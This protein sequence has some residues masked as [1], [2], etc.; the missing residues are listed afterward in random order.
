MH[1]S[2]RRIV[3][4][5]LVS[6][7]DPDNAGYLNAIETAACLCTL[8]GS[9]RAHK[10]RQVFDLFDDDD[11]GWISVDELRSF[12]SSVFRMAFTIE[13][14]E[15]SKLDGTFEECVNATVI[16]CFQYNGLPASTSRLNKVCT[17]SAGCMTSLE[18]RLTHDRA[19][20]VSW[21]RLAGHHRRPSSCRGTPAQCKA[22]TKR[23]RALPP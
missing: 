5:R 21:W 18:S 12:L 16:G 8:S 19:V 3:I 15:A 23:T 6:I 17:C 20:A 1:A 14:A 13:P 10:A 4:D 2:G 22:L 9:S 11:D 7:F